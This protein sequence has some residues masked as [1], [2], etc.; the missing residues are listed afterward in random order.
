M[1]SHERLVEITQVSFGLT[2][3]LGN[4]ESARI[5][6]QAKVNKGQDWQIVLEE[7]RALVSAEVSV[8]R[9]VHARRSQGAQRPF[10]VPE[11]P[12]PGMAMDIP[13]PANPTPPRP[14]GSMRRRR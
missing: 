8:E 14:A 5:D 10:P 9:D 11:E 12:P 1:G 7:L 13:E 2:A 4:Y 3:N 6:L